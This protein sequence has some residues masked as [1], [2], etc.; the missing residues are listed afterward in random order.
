[1]NSRVRSA[2]IVRFI[3][4]MMVVGLVYYGVAKLGL[5]AFALPS[6]KVTPTWPASGVALAAILLLGYRVAPGIWIAAFAIHLDILLGG[7]DPV[8]L[9]RA[10]VVALMLGGSGVVEPLL[11]AI[12]LN[13]SGGL[14]RALDRPTDVLRLAILAGVLTCGIGATIGV[15]SLTLGGLIPRVEYGFS[16]VTWWLAEITG[17]VAVTP[18]LLAWSRPLRMKLARRQ[19]LEILLLGALLAGV[20][21]VVF[22]IWSPGARVLRLEVYLIVP[23]LIWAAYRF[24]PR[25]AALAT[26]TVA[27]V[28]LWATVHGVGPYGD[29]LG[30]APLFSLQV[31]VAVVTTQILFLSASLEHGKGA[32]NELAIARDQALAA[33][34]H[35]SE[36]LAT[37][38]HEI[39]TPMNGVIG[40]LDLL[41]DTPL[42][43]QQHDFALTGRDSA[44]ALLVII[45]HI[46]DFSRIESGKLL[47]EIVDFELTLAVEGAAEVLAGQARE[48][49]LALMTYISPEIPGMLRGDHSRLR[50][51]LVNLIG[52]AVKFTARGE[53]TAR[54]KLESATASHVTVRFTVS[55]TGIGLSAGAQ[56]RLF[57]SFSQADAS[58]TRKY[59]GTGL[60]LAISKRLVEL[61]GGEIGVQSEVGKG[62]TFWCTA[63]FERSPLAARSATPAADRKLKGLRV[64][65]VDDTATNREIVHSYLLA[66]GMRNG[67]VASGRES[68]DILRR[69]AA[70]GDPY[71]VAIIDPVLPEEMD[72]FGLACAIKEDPALA[73]T[74]L[75]LLMAFDQRRQGVNGLEARFSAYLTKPVRQWKLF[76]AITTA[77]SDRPGGVAGRQQEETASPLS[78]PTPPGLSDTAEV[79]GGH[80]LVLLVEDNPVNQKVAR[81]QLE[82]LGYRVRVVGNGRE[83]VEAVARGEGYA[84]ILM[85]MQMP[86][87]DGVTATKAI[88]KAEIASGRRLPIVAMTASAMEGDRETCIASGMDD[89]ISKPVNREKLRAALERWVHTAVPE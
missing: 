86:E 13:R 28:A 82:N 61:M 20:T 58:T 27:T 24:G 23:F 40:M 87:M 15:T 63:R 76:D 88:R 26:G 2:P 64:L 72:G 34:R 37:M 9:T 39:R 21:L 78:P 35:K 49:D 79:P 33:T 30:A 84:L 59:G 65:V 32:E 17:I 62:S 4:M 77:V 51:I 60:G 14:S 38:S 66:W 75:I 3:A 42:S 41:L 5:L 6:G 44:Q 12:L 69:A 47:L 71:D 29:I 54:A 11:G 67:S 68:L 81:M 31:F 70:D 53:V 85:D 56:Q 43:R 22:D 19:L 36:F 1:M 89:Y 74:R 48:K 45:N 83:A 25:G 8:P 18:L 16:W 46:L 50:Q 73:S 57:Q 7:S 10:I 55:D 52:N 80:Q